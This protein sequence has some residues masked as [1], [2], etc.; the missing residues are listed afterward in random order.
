V[1]DLVINDGFEQLALCVDA[2]VNAWRFWP[3][4]W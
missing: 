2:G 3:A 1:L 4:R